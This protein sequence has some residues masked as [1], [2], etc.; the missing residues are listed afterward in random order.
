[1]KPI[2]VILVALYTVSISLFSFFLYET[3]V[4]KNINIVLQVESMNHE[5]NI[6]YYRLG[7]KE[8][9]ELKELIHAYNQNSSSNSLLSIFE[10]EREHYILL[11]SL[12]FGLTAVVS[13]YFTASKLIEKSDLEDLK[14][15]QIELNNSLDANLTEVKEQLTFHK[16]ANLS[17]H[18]RI[19]SN[20]NL[21][22]G[23][24]RIHVVNMSDYLDYLEQKISKIFA[25]FPYSKLDRQEYTEFGFLVSNLILGSTVYAKRKLGY[26]IAAKNY[27]IID[28]NIIFMGIIRFFSMHCNKSD[29]ALLIRSIK[30]TGQEE[31][32]FG[33]Y[34]S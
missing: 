19:G 9:N 33:D 26:H 20:L 27:W 15:K 31:I 29:F 8:L 4:A 24:T 7:A 13:I 16:I 21:S 30:S 5:A 6:A 23:N 11:T 18:L 32:D 12:L 34:D 14:L 22:K 25:D 28:E 3:R 17:Y 1:M 2:I 10:R